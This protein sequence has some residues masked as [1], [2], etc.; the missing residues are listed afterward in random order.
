MSPRPSKSLL[1]LLIE[2]RG[3]RLLTQEGALVGALPDAAAGAA[4]QEAWA[5]ALR[6]MVPPG[7]QI[8]I[9]MAHSNLTVQCQDAPYLSVREQRDVALRL[10]AAESGSSHL[11]F[12]ATLDTDK[13]ADGG[14]V[15]WVA[16]HPRIE[17][18]DWLEAIK[19]AGLELVHAL[20]L[21]RAVIRGLESVENLPQDRFVLSL[22]SGHEGHL[23]IFRGHTLSIMRSFH[24]PDGSDELDELVYEEV[25]RLLQFMKQKH[26]GLGFDSLLV[27]GVPALS[28]PLAA[29]FQGAL[30]LAPRVIAPSFW[31]FVQQGMRLERNRKDGLNLVPI[32]VQE[33]LQRKLFKATVWIASALLLLLFVVAGMLLTMQERALKLAAEQAEEN[34]AKR[35]Q[36][37]SQEVLIVNARLPLVRLKL[38]EK[39]QAE[40]M[41]G[42]SRITAALLQAPRGV[43][44]EKVEVCEIAGNQMAHHFTVSG[45]ALTER[46]FSVGPLAQ[47]LMFLAKMPGV[48]LS[49]I[50]DLSIS[51]RMEEQSNKLD[52]QAVTR[53]TF[54]GMVTL[55]ARANERAKP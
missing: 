4:R 46:D 19:G 39:R 26:R 42:L 52:Q 6:D 40:A 50:K 22:E 20:P 25:S 54:E 53:F 37:T 23:F 17:I 11:S 1:T 49:P 5:Q 41:A 16:I 3:A 34:L 12:A 2:D 21:Q 27:V 36:A 18:A 10:A 24:L 43:V 15:L 47:Y 7:S 29:R 28:G 32:E 55:P 13:V 38:A 51:D 45:T 48:V 9:L 44:I 35:E 33:A 31:P 14:H 8:Q 30:R